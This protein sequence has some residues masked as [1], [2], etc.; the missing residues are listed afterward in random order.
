MIEKLRPTALKSCLLGP[1]WFPAPKT[2]PRSSANCSSSL[3]YDSERS[4][5]ARE[6]CTSY[7]AGGIHTSIVSRLAGR[8]TKA[9][10]LSVRIDL[11]PCSLLCLIGQDD[12]VRSSSSPPHIEV[13]EIS[14]LL[15]GEA[16]RTG[17]D[18]EVRTSSATS[19]SSKPFSRPHNSIK[20]V[21][22]THEVEPRQ[23]PLDRMQADY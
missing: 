19:F 6:N 10:L 3:I 1:P 7:H 22:Q 4:S 9:R 11:V 17:N 13:L 15:D 16:F 20:S 18:P 2:Y 21:G 5:Q 8:Q 23:L 12:G 14:K